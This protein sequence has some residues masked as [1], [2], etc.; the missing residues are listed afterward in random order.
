M[1]A[2]EWIKRLKIAFFAAGEVVPRLA[3]KALRLAILFSKNAVVANT[4]HTSMGIGPPF[5]YTK[6]THDPGQSF[7]GHNIHS[8]AEG[9]LR[10]AVK[11]WLLHPLPS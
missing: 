3:Q 11:A 2:G 1:Q 10:V 5:A 7:G 8:E 6:P 9:G 4:A